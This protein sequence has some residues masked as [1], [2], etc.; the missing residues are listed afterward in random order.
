MP[1]LRM[2]NLQKWDALPVRTN[3]C[4][5]GLAIACSVVLR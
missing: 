1:V 2:M 4:Q 3:T 5:P